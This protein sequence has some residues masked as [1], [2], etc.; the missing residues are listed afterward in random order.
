MKAF[1]VLRPG[2][3]STIQDLGRPGY[4]KYGV[5]V[6]GAM[7]KFALRVANLL[8]GN[9]EGEA[10]LEMTLL[11]PQLE[12]LADLRVAITGGSFDPRVNR[13]PVP[14]WQPLSLKK[15]DVLSFSPR[16]PE[17]GFRAYLAVAGAIEIAPVMGSRSTH[18]LS[19]LGGLGRE[20]AR[21]DLLHMGPNPQ[22][23]PSR[24][25]EPDQIPI[26]PHSWVI[27]VLPGPQDDHFTPAGLETFF[28]GEYQ[29]TSEANRMGYRL[30][31][32]KIEH[33]HGGPDIVSD[34]TPPGSIQVPGDGT[35]IVLMAD[36]QTTGGYAKIA[37]AASP[38]LDRLAQASV[39]DRLSFERIDIDQAYKMIEQTENRL[40]E[41]KAQLGLA[42][43]PDGKG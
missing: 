28:S 29:I 6:S 42:S 20:L 38:E 40:R 26:Y 39:G 32:P 25:L 27:R 33:S 9:R 14:M 35:P 37:V 30:E 10:C 2:V 16:P 22:K 41:I 5:S 12:L 7:D 36:G 43:Q 18:I 23:A 13:E 3:F 17:S 4:Q 21:G 24:G 15:G 8:V 34:A 1:R 31:G 11:G 19:K